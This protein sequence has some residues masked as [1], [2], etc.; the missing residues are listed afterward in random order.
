[1]LFLQYKLDKTSILKIFRIDLTLV[2]FF[3]FTLQ[4]L[5]CKC[6]YLCLEQYDRHYHFWKDFLN[7]PHLLKIE[8]HLI[9]KFDPNVLIFR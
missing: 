4:N 1:M 2:N 9:K 5:K 7:F 6:K 8:N 3:N